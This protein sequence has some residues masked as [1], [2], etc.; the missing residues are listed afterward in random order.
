MVNMGAF[1]HIL[2]PTQHAAFSRCPALLMLGLRA[3]AGDS[4]RAGVRGAVVTNIV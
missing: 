4:S 3:G 2:A 1:M